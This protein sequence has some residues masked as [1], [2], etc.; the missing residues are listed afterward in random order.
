MPRI[1]LPDSERPAWRGRMMG[2]L[3]VTRAW[4]VVATAYVLAAW[5]VSGTSAVPLTATTSSG[6]HVAAV[7][8][9]D[10]AGPR[11]EPVMSF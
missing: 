7:G 1:L 3:H 9:R 11:E 10:E 5:K 6:A 8:Q 2:Y 4:Y